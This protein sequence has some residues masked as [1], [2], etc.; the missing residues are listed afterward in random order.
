VSLEIKDRIKVVRKTIGITQAD[1]GKQ[2]GI[3]D[4]SV[5]RLESGE[6][7]PSEQ[8]I[9][10]ICREF[11]V[12]YDWLKNGIEPMMVPKEYLD[13]AKVENRLEGSN[14]F[15]KQI[16]YGLA[17]M[18]DEWW[19]MAERVLRDALEAKKDR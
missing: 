15:V 9:K 14:E 11:G 7:N 19:E 6:N 12:S 8:T 17:D 1:F 4:A 3:T 13:R 2:I 10:L 16:F 5:S 18:P